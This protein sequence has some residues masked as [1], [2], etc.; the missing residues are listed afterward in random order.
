MTSKNTKLLHN[1]KNLQSNLQTEQLP[2]YQNASFLYTNNLKESDYSYSRK[3]NP[4]R[5][6][7][8]KKLALLDHT[9]H[10]FAVANGT[11]AITAVISLLNSHDH[12]L[13]SE[14]L[15]SGSQLLI[16]N[17]SKQY[18]IQ[19][20]ILS[21]QEINNL[22]L[23]SSYIQNN[24]R[25]M[26]FESPANPTQ[27]TIN[28]PAIKTIAQKNNIHLAI[29]NSLLSS[30]LQQPL[31]IG[32]DI[33]IQSAAKHL[34]GH[35]DLMAGVISVNNKQL[36]HKLYEIIQLQGLGLTAFDS[37]LLSR[38][39]DTL[40]LRITQQQQSAQIIVKQLSNHPEVSHVYYSGLGSII[41]F[42][43]KHKDKTSSW[44]NEANEFFNIC[45]NF[46]SIRSSISLPNIMSHKETFERCEKENKIPP[47]D[48]NLIR[49]SIG[50]ESIE[51]IQNALFNAF[52]TCKQYNQLLTQNRHC[53]AK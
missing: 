46:G 43:L 50:I 52:D 36:H 10:S 4:N 23:L 38:S 14:H 11:Q 53:N 39:L 47:F 3:A 1:A 13:I 51:D 7:L 24:T 30:Y 25:L 28:I 20:S 17:L 21:Y 26:F 49:L 29:D 2:I 42:T 45:R 9:Q 19:F 15:Y 6:E 31:D 12:M 16:E 35:N 8:E 44:L 32:A 48:P 27:E 22:E 40:P 34:G 37:W 5:S 41:A 18:Q 33:A